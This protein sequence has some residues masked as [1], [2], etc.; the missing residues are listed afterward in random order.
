MSVKKCNET[1]GNRT[2]DLPACSAVPQPTAPPRAPSYTSNPPMSCTACTEP[3]CLYKGALYLPLHYLLCFVF[4]SEKLSKFTY[5]L[6][7]FN[8]VWPHILNWY[9]IYYNCQEACKKKN[10]ICVIKKNEKSMKIHLQEIRYG[11]ESA[12]D[13]VEWL[14]SNLRVQFS[15]SRVL[16]DVIT[17]TYFGIYLKMTRYC[18]CCWAVVIPSEA[19]SSS[20]CATV[21]W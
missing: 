7:V 13:R 17:E 20:D 4:V 9:L 15:Y 2:R 16:G 21:S 19:E 14:N 3:Q 11:V 8:K 10:V 5:N 12:Q 1:V 18:C 6:I